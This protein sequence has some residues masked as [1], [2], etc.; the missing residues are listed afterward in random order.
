MDPALFQM[1]LFPFQISQ[2]ESGVKIIAGV[3]T[4]LALN[5]LQNILR[6]RSELFQLLYIRIMDK[7]QKSQFCHQPR[8]LIL[9]FGRETFYED[10]LGATN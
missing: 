9:Y 10:E 1:V 3:D 7:F 4:I 5:S 2:N 6:F 8:M